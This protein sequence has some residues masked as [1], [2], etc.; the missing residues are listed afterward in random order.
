MHVGQEFFITYIF[1]YS[2]NLQ[3]YFQDSRM[4]HSS[5]YLILALAEQFRKTTLA[6]L[7]MSPVQDPGTG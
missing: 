4:W 3:I 7:Y 6:G 2:N 1:F 5:I